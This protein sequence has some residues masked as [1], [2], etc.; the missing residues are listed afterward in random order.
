[1]ILFNIIVYTLF[2]ILCIFFIRSGIRKLKEV[3]KSQDLAS[4]Y[5]N[6]EEHLKAIKESEDYEKGYFER[7]R[8]GEQSQQF[9]SP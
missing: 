8:K 3:H 9:L 2:G 5:T 1:M 7:I 6:E 4:L